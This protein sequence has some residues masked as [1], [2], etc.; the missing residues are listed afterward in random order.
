[1]SK[2]QYFNILQCNIIAVSDNIEKTLEKKIQI[3]VQLLEIYQMSFRYVSI[4]V[5]SIRV[6]CWLVVALVVE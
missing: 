6:Q 3:H 5:M 1:M 4:K 2:C